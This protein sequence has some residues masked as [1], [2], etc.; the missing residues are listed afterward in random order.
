MERSRAEIRCYIALLENERK[1]ASMKA[2]ISD[3][4]SV[5]TGWEQVALALQNAVDR[6]QK[7]VEAR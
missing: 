3:L 2:K 5:K 7:E 4:A 1:K 6:L